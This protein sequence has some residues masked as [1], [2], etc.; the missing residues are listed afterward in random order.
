[1]NVFGDDQVTALQIVSGETLA[2]AAQDEETVL[3][4]WAFTA[5]GSI[6]LALYAFWIRL[7]IQEAIVLDAASFPLF[8]P[9]GSMNNLLDTLRTLEMSNSCSEPECGSVKVGSAQASERVD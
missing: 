5:G 2:L 6:P 9:Q 8:L 4:E 1:M 3:V 7:Q